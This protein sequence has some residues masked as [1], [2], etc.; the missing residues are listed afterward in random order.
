[1]RMRRWGGGFGTRL[2]LF[3]ASVAVVAAG[4]AAFLTVRQVSRQV[5]ESVE[6]AEHDVDNIVRGLADT[7]VPAV[8]WSEPRLRATVAKLAEKTGQRIRVSFEDVVIDSDTLDGGEPRPLSTRPDLTVDSLPVPDYTGVEPHNWFD[9]TTSAAIDF[10]ISVDTARCMIDHSQEVTWVSGVLGVPTIEVW[11]L[12]G[13]IAPDCRTESVAG[14]EP[15]LSLPES[16]GDMVNRVHTEYIECVPGPDD[17]GRAGQGAEPRPDDIP[18]LQRAFRAQIVGLE[19]ASPLTLSIGIGGEPR[20]APIDLWPALIAAAIVALIAIVGTA[21]MSRRVLRPVVKLTAAARQ[22]GDGDLAG[23][24]PVRGRDQIAELATSFNRMAASL[25]AS[26]EQQR[27]MVGDIA[28]E[29]RTPLANIR[30]YLEAL[31]DGVLAPDPV[32]FQS[33]HEEAV[34][35]QRL[36]DDLQDLAEAESGTMIYHR[37]RLDVA[38]LLSTSRTAHLAAAEAR[39]VRLA[40]TVHGD[41]VIHGDADRL[42]QVIGNL[43]TNA[44]RATPAGGTVTLRTQAQPDAVY[45]A[46]ADTGHG[47]T[48]DDLPHVFD[49]FWRADNARSRS[50]GGSGLGLAIAREIVAAHQGSITVTSTAGKGTV[51]TMRFPLV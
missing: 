49:R 32:L 7:A 31:K 12:G 9:Y 38:D 19:A 17:P 30:G 4:A 33:L 39:G 26:K 50:T 37:A 41:P 24:V 40:M 2:F 34:L 45:V 10:R 13:D 18:C 16:G 27:T 42:R 3:T 51:F 23:R 6:V 15:P 36:I 35:Q 48:E 22:L 43:I 46:V 47:I 14:A 44:L 25:Q 29:L 1:M 11:R 21:L 28:H 5:T 8:E 20:A